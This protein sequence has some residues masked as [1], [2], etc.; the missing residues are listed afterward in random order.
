MC[1]LFGQVTDAHRDA[2]EPLC[3]A[4]NAL[5]VQSHRHPHGWGVAWYP[6]RSG[7]PEVRRGV[8]AAHADVDF[9]DAARRA[10]S[11]VVLAHVR[12]ASI[13]AVALRN[14]HPFVEGRWVLA[15]NGTVARFARVRSV[16]AS[17]PGRR[18]AAPAPGLLPVPVVFLVG[19]MSGSNG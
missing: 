7:A 3:S 8:M 11:R 6:D 15:H 17:E 10:R 2:Q 1:R 19:A 13:G 16:R 12:D 9:C 18:L 14:T 5:R 4:E